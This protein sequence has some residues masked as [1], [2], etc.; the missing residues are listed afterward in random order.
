MAQ[1]ISDIKYNSVYVGP[2]AGMW[3]CLPPCYGVEPSGKHCESACSSSRTLGVT[4]GV[5]STRFGV[6]GKPNG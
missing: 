6:E 3:L 4:H 5:S 2:R 1:F